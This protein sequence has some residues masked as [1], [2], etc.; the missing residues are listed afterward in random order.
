[1]LG[2]LA[3]VA[4]PFVV[5]RRMAIDFGSTCPLSAGKVPHLRSVFPTVVRG[6]QVSVA[7]YANT[8]GMTLYPFVPGRHPGVTSGLTSLQALFRHSCLPQLSLG[9]GWVHPGAC[10]PATMT[11]CAV[12]LP[13]QER[14]V[15]FSWGSL[16]IMQV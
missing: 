7:V 12:S 14:N 4:A 5:Y 16:G 11:T 15:M 3:P 8:H 6:L 10:L 1:V 13:G 9:S 2:Q